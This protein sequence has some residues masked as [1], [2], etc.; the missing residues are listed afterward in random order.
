MQKSKQFI[1]FIAVFI[2]LGISPVE[3]QSKGEALGSLQSKGSTSIFVNVFVPAV[4]NG[5]GEAAGARF[6]DGLLGSEVDSAEDSILCTV[7]DPTDTPLNI[8]STPNGPEIVRTLENGSQVIPYDIAFD[9]DDRHFLLVGDEF[10]TWGWVFGPY[11]SC[12]KG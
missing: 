3:A 7:T 6:I 12:F 10:N 9:E 2:S 4:L 8:R 1:A 11:V 5:M